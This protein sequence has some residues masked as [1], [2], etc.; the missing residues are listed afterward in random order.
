MPDTILLLQLEHERVFKLL[1]LV[2]RQLANLVRH[3][4]VDHR[5]LE[6]AFDYLAGYPDQCHHPKE[7]LLYRKLGSRHP[8]MAKSLGALVEEHEELARLTDG[9]RR[10]LG[11]LRR[12][13][14]GM[15]DLFAERLREF[16]DLYRHHMSMEER[17]FFPAALQSLSRNDW[18]EIDFAVFDQPDPLIDR[19]TEERFAQ[20]RDEITQL[21]EAEKTSAALRKDA[22]WLGRLEGI[23][24]FNE[25]M[26]QSGESVRLHRSSDG[27]Y[28]LERRGSVLVHIPECSEPRAVWCAYFFLKGHSRSGMATPPWV[29]P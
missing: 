9:L 26:Q 23:A 25:A 15:K 6:N 1:D 4:P 13:E 27:S 17:H 22:A 24:D 3:Q 14:A 8:G 10:N 11:G 2:A 20:L 16:I 29:V 21:G 18:E 28:D 12:G 5:L 19:S 7:D